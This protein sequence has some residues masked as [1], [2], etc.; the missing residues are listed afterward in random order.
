MDVKQWLSENDRL[1]NRLGPKHG[2]ENLDGL[3]NNKDQENPASMGKEEPHLC[4]KISSQQDALPGMTQDEIEPGDSVSNISSRK[5]GS[6]A[7]SSCSSTSSAHVKAEADIAALLAR[8][9]LLK[10]KHDLE[11]QEVEI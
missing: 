10:D 8:Q 6:K 4:N 11:Q 1:T 5:H 9:R 3:S 7:R 2:N